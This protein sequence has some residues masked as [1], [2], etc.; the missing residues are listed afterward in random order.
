[1]VS[2]TYKQAL[3]VIEA[4]ALKETQEISDYLRMKIALLF[5]FLVAF[6]AS[7]QSFQIINAG[8]LKLGS[9]E[10]LTPGKVTEYFGMNV[11]GL[12]ESIIRVHVGNESYDKAYEFK[13]DPTRLFSYFFPNNLSKLGD[14]FI[15][16]VKGT[17]TIDII[18]PEGMN[19][20]STQI[21]IDVLLP[22]K[23]CRAKPT[24]PCK[25]ADLSKLSSRQ[26][27]KFVKAFTNS[28]KGPIVLEP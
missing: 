22:R 26:I 11:S 1:M 25:K 16:G 15:R 8:E 4:R 5:I 13:T 6:E 17:M 12:G 27:K 19:S 3:L 23:N 21:E 28:I 18:S 9:N 24:I 14:N 10:I 20:A 2:I 7:A